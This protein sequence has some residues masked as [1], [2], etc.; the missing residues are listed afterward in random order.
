MLPGD[1]LKTWA[2]ELQNRCVGLSFMGNRVS[3][4]VFFPARWIIYW[5]RKIHL[6]KVRQFSE[7]E[8]FVFLPPNLPGT[9][10]PVRLFK[11]SWLFISPSD[12]VFKS[13]IL[14][15][16][17]V[18]LAISSQ[19]KF[20]SKGNSCRTKSSLFL[21][22]GPEE[23]RK[24]AGGIAKKGER[25]R[26]RGGGGALKLQTIEGKSGKRF[27]QYDLFFWGGKRSIS[28]DAAAVIFDF[29]GN[30]FLFFPLDLGESYPAP[31]A[32]SSSSSS[33]I[34]INGF[35]SSSSLSSTS[36]SPSP[37]HLPKKKF[38]WQRRP[39][40]KSRKH[41]FRFSKLQSARDRMFAGESTHQS[42]P[43]STV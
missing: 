41:I 19:A 29:R 10:L 31:F 37:I 43:S 17:S 36:A 23:R 28:T 16:Q 5:N 30:A 38:F 35:P 25:R 4:I 42:L 7:T 13:L 2:L 24:K 6:V 27:G 8:L 14:K 39:F 33:S 9:I 3:C 34:E 15:I 20:R 22:L 12:Y 1:W 40:L 32:L 26:G 18:G 21:P 11:R